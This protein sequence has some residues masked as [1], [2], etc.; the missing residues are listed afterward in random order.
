MGLGDVVV[1]AQT[2]LVAIRL[3]QELRRLCFESIG[4]DRRSLSAEWGW[5]SGL[6]P[7]QTPR[8]S[9][10]VNRRGRW[11]NGGVKHRVMS[12]RSRPGEVAR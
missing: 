3:V 10:M 12:V 2:V 9:S 5:L 8:G 4:R 7:K 11:L 1:P 6:S